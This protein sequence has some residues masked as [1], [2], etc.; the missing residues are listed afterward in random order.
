MKNVTLRLLFVA[1]ALAIAPVLAQENAPV[2]NITNATWE[3]YRDMYQKSP[4]CSKDEITLW[5]CET[6]TRVYSLCSS[7]S[8]TRTS[9]YIQY[10][11]SRGGR[12]VFMYP[13]ERKQ[14]LGSFIYSVSGNGDAYVEFTSNGYGYTLVDPLRYRSSILVSAPGPSGKQTEIECR[15]ANTMLQINYTMRLM[16]ASGVWAG[17]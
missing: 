17:Y 15:K 4:L 9:G 10:R 8:M 7:R 5:S 13:I 16:Y 14:P 1:L 3:Q 12:T 2:S 11:A 6:G